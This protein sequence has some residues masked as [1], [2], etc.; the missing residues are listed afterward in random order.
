MESIS[1]AYLPRIYG[2][3]Q[4]YVYGGLMYIGFCKR[5]LLAA[6]N[7]TSTYPLEIDGE[8]AERITI[9]IWSIVSTFTYNLKLFNEFAINR[10]HIF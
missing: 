1:L 4:T 3:R 5:V 8:I 6:P 7:V 10:I 2:R 9:F